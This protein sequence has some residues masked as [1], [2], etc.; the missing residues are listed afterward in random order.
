MCLL[1]YFVLSFLA[2]RALTFGLNPFIDN[3]VGNVTD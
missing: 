3:E 2:D 1:A